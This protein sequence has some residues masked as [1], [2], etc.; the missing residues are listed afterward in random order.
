MSIISQIQSL[1]LKVVIVSFS[2]AELVVN[3]CS[4]S[5]QKNLLYPLALFRMSS[6]LLGNSL[7]FPTVVDVQLTLKA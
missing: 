4:Q 2:S 1:T 7:G 5:S 3:D 6:T